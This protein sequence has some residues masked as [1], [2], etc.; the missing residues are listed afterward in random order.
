ML[1]YGSLVLS[2]LVL[3]S[4]VL[5]TG[6]YENDVQ[7]GSLSP[8]AYPLDRML[9]ISDRRRSGVASNFAS[10]VHTPQSPSHSLL[11]CIHPGEVDCPCEA[12]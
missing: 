12:G 5:A 4:L 3:V 1:V 9:P 10:K 7:D 2:V 11:D 6:A 8:I